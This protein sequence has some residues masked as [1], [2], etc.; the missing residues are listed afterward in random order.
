MNKIKLNKGTCI[1][2]ENE[3]LNCLSTW[4]ELN[5]KCN[6]VT[7]NDSLISLGIE[8]ESPI[9]ILFDLSLKVFKWQ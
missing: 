3:Q 2:L 1:H 5:E 6:R 9:R 8:I 7:I 4:F